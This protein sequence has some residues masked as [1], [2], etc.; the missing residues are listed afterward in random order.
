[1][2]FVSWE[3]GLCVMFF[4]RDFLRC[5]EVPNQAQCLQ[6]SQYPPAGIELAAVQSQARAFRKGMMII[7]PTLPKSDEPE[8]LHWTRNI[9]PLH[10]MGR[11]ME[12]ARPVIM[13]KPPDEP[14]PCNGD[15]KPPAN[16][17]SDP[18]PIAE[19]I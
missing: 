19:V 2:F 16:P 13:R 14:M 12:G 11:N 15:Y 18:T 4:N 10:A 5:D 7:V 3:E 1:M 8:E 17:P 9:M 6:P